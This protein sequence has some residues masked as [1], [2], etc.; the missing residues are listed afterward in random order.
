MVD[1]IS[2]PPAPSDPLGKT[3]TRVGSDSGETLRAGSSCVPTAAPDPRDVEGAPFGRY[4]LI[5]EVGRGGMGVVWKAWDTR[6]KRIVA[7]KQILSEDWASPDAR[8][9]FLREAQ[10]AAQLRHPHIVGVHDVGEEDGRH[11]LTMDFVEGLPLSKVP[12]STPEQAM[13]WVKELAEALAY[14]HAQGVIHRDVKPAN[15]LVDREGKAHVVD[16]GLAR[17][18]DAAASAALT[19]SGAV[20]GTP[21]Y[22]SPEQATGDR[23][24]VGPA[25]DQFSAGVVLYELLT[26][27][28]PFDGQA[29][30]DLLNAIAETDPT[31]PRRINSSVSCEAETICL[32]ALEKDPARRY[33]SMAELAAD[34]GRALAGEPILASPVSA[35]SM[36]YRRARKHR[37]A[38]SFAMLAVV[39]ALGAF[40]WNEARTRDT[41]DRAQGLVASATATELLAS[42]LQGRQAE[43]A[44]REAA[45]GFA[46][47]LAVDPDNADARAGKDRAERAALSVSDARTRADN[48]LEQARSRLERAASLFY[49]ENATYEDVLKQVDPAL[50]AIDEA[51]RLAPDHA[52]ARYLRGRALALR[53]DDLMGYD[54][55]SHALLIDK[56][57]APA[58]FER[59]R[60][61]FMWA[62]LSALT[63][64]GA[65]GVIDARHANVQFQEAIQDLNALRG[66]LQGTAAADGSEEWQMATE[67]ALVMR[68][69][70]DGDRNLAVTKAQESLKRHPVA[71][72][73]EMFLWA[74]GVMVPGKAGTDRLDE[75]IRIRSHFPLA[76]YCRGTLK[77]QNGDLEGAVTDLSDAIA[78]S[79]GMN[80]AW[81]HRGLA[82][83][84]LDRRDEAIADFDEALRL[85][86]TMYLALNGRGLAKRHKGDLAGAIADFNEMIKF[87]PD[88]PGPWVNRAGSK[89]AMGDTEG[90]FADAEEA[91][92]LDRRYAG[93]WLGLAE[94][95][96]TR[97]DFDAAI[98]ACSR[99]ILTA[100]DPSDLL[101][102]RGVY[103][104]RKGDLDAGEVDLRTVLER[105][106]SHAAAHY[107]LGCVHAMRAARSPERTDEETDLAFRS[108]EAAVEAGFRDAALM[109]SDPD[110]DALRNDPRFQELLGRVRRR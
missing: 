24:R 60:L 56:N 39:I 46:E 70:L 74:L 48:L 62:Y 86:P 78:F 21:L 95:F 47:A 80:L 38:V 53:G 12:R 50:A 79:P 98:D 103:R 2:L 25:S 34:L 8:E 108:L 42:R 73:R 3:V 43:E 104:I 64:P 31:P 67:F 55:F 110:L 94:A 28:T 84:L 65:E 85:F 71:D 61:R 32:R 102:Q 18:T 83:D 10:L 15:V 72:G 5:E 36:I 109:E 68:A 13:Q 22:M 19:G 37:A 77:L 41:R 63:I 101:S 93:I 20:V 87:W 69:Y 11:F 81:A 76:R 106:P 58:L 40:V 100:E 7:L 29:L 75:A 54:E 45:S 92:R 9:R 82:R 96:E 14:A 16:F 90:A 44:Y 30:R 91:F 97:K 17:E 27:R 23:A 88:V 59:A 49:K 99:G 89:A 52:T 33:R 1:P 6:L 4:R 107:N 35:A 26:G 57:F 66:A 51:L 105:N